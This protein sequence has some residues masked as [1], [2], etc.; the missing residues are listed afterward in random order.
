M[1]FIFTECERNV[2]KTS[3]L[4]YNYYLLFFMLSFCTKKKKKKKKTTKT[5]FV[6]K[7]NINV[8]YL[9]F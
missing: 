7:Q 2:E 9:E 8:F 5:E 1:Y 4:K 3:E 6:F